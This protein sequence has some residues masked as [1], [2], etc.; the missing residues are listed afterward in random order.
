MEEVAVRCN[1]RRFGDEVFALWRCNDCGS[2]HCKDEVDLIRFYAGYPVHKLRLNYWIRLAYANYVRRLTKFGLDRSHRILDYGCGEGLLIEYLR[3]RGYRDVTGFDPYVAKFAD[4]SRIADKYDCV[5]AQDVI[6]HA[7]QPRSVFMQLLDCVCPGGLL[8]IGTP[9]AERINLGDSE[10]YSL[11]LHV[12]YHRHILSRKILL[13]I[14][15]RANL[16]VVK[17]WDRHYTDTP[18]PTCNMQF[19]R[20]YVWQCGNWLD[21]LFEKPRPGALVRSPTLLFHAFFGYLVPWRT[22]MMVLF[23]KPLDN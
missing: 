15:R 8:C 18:F 21:V 20:S 13:Q 17:L 5:I 23:H 19:T 10:R 3:R 16:R 9:D 4:T 6:E 14:A 1:V 12:P 22:E 11:S 2:L 7:D